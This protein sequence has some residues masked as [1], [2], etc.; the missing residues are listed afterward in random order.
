M[1]ARLAGRVAVV[2]G[3]GS[4][5]GLATVRRL[6]VEG[7]RVVCV[8]I[9]AE[10]GRAAAW[11]VDGDF[12]ECD[13]TDE[14]AVRE[15]LDG[16]AARHGRIDIAVNTAGVSAP[17]D[18]VN[19]TGVQ[20]CCRYVIPHMRRQ[21]RGSIVNTVPTPTPTGSRP[22]HGGRKGGVLALTRELGVELARQGI[23]V[24]AVCPGPVATPALS[25]LFAADPAQ[26]VRD[27]SGVPMGRLGEPAEI[28]AA[29][30]FLAS[31]DASFV[32]A[33]RFAVDGGAGGAYPVPQ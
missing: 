13:V 5:I 17:D 33:A 27:L 11:E 14:T 29:I 4:G 26:V 24:N 10:E 2:T 12:V 25:E 32:T 16:V 28:A 8:D 3:A 31:D 19:T 22:D 9:A 1:G 18:E 23:R 21:G 15:L 6:A 7:A 30:A 20:L